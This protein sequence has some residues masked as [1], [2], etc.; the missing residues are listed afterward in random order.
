LR[1]LRDR[2]AACPAPALA[3]RTTRRYR[4]GQ[5]RLLASGRD[6]RPVA[7]AALDDGLLVRAVGL[8]ADGLVPEILHRT[9][10]GLPRVDQVLVLDET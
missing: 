10:D 6:R 9:P 2:D 1:R 8:H 3:F 7:A 4:L 5:L